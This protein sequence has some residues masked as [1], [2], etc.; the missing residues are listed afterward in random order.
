MFRG[1]NAFLTYFDPIPFIQFEIQAKTFNFTKC[2]LRN[3]LTTFL[4]KGYTI[5]WDHA[6]LPKP[7]I[8]QE[9][10]DEWGPKFIA[11][12]WHADVM[13]TKSESNSIH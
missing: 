1:S 7:P 5:V 13:L 10:V 8:T 9:I 4:E 6:S 3:L 2:N 11:N 12:R